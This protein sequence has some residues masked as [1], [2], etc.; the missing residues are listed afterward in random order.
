[1]ALIEDLISELH[2]AKD[3]ESAR[4]AGGEDLLDT[5]SGDSTLSPEAID[6]LKQ[7]WNYE[8][9]QLNRIRAAIATL[10]SLQDHGYPIRKSFNVNQEIANELRMKQKQMQEFTN[11]LLPIVIGADVAIITTAA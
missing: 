7:K 3:M 4:V 6:I 8:I 11:E 1:M 2:A 10:E 9:V 5:A